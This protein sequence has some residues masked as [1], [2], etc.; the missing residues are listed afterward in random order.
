[1]Y[2]TEV[3]NVA[4]LCFRALDGSTY[5]VRCEV[6]NLLGVLLSTTQSPRAAQGRYRIGQGFTYNLLIRG[7]A[8]KISF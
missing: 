2:T 6:A 3:D 1:M 4:S 8:I 5:D 7:T